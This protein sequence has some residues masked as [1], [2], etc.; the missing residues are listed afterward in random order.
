MPV[1]PLPPLS[2][3]HRELGGSRASTRYVILREGRLL[4]SGKVADGQERVAEVGVILDSK[5]SLR[6]NTGAVEK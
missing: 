4:A 3:A 5:G 2:G 6:G 1:R